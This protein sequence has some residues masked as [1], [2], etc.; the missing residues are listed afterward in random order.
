MDPPS[1][2]DRNLSPEPEL[3]LADPEEAY[4]APVQRKIKEQLTE[5][6]EEARLSLKEKR[7]ELKKLETQ[8]ESVGVDLYSAQQSLARNQTTLEGQDSQKES[9][10]ALRA[11]KATKRDSA[12]QQYT[13][14]RSE[15]DKL[16]ADHFRC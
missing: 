1:D 15:T 10:T 16:R 3:D 2:D 6:L 12:R 4:L 8:R 14:L 13:T 7:H 9:L 11:E 5:Q